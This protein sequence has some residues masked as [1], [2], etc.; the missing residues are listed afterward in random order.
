ME[1]QVFLCMACSHGF[2][3]VKIFVFFLVLCARATVHVGI[4]APTCTYF[5]FF[6]EMGATQRYQIA[7]A[8]DLDKHCQYMRRSFQESINHMVSDWGQKMLRFEQVR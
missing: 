3:K 7:V 8:D 1:P 6:F 4:I 5:V 2:E